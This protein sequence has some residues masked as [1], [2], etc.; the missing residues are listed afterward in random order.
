MARHAAWLYCLH[1]L[2]ALSSIAPFVQ[3]A[4]NSERAC[5]IGKDAKGKA[6]CLPVN[7]QPALYTSTFGDCLGGS[8]IDVTRFDAAYYK[9]NSTITFHLQGNTPITNLSLMREWPRDRCWRTRLTRAV[10]I[11]VY[12]YGSQRF[13]K[14]FDPC[15]AN[16]NR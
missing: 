3:A 10:Y 14:I 8:I 5:D 4:E 16:I 9:D 1:L 12:A 7:R 6:I 13:E 11:G 15:Q 2:L